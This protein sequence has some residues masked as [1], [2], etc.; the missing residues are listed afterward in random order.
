[1]LRFRTDRR[2]A[3]D[4]QGEQPLQSEA[5][6]KEPQP[7]S[8]STQDPLVKLRAGWDCT[9]LLTESKRGLSRA[10]WSMARSRTC[11]VA[12][13]RL[14]TNQRR[15][16][17]RA[18]PSPCASS[19]AWRCTAATG[20]LRSKAAMNVLAYWRRCPPPCPA[21]CTTSASRGEQAGRGVWTCG[22][23]ARGSPPRR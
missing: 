4:E 5:C 2:G 13:P 22:L 9:S 18:R 17:R 23:A 11:A 19:F 8:R 21:T 7:Q 12:T 20:R 14:P 10:A 16:R 3:L 15:P 1:M 6:A